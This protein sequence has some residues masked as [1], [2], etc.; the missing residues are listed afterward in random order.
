MT[1]SS[2]SEVTRPTVSVPKVLIAEADVAYRIVKLPGAARV[3]VCALEDERRAVVLYERAGS[4]DEVASVGVEPA[5]HGAHQRPAR[6]PRNRLLHID[7][8]HRLADAVRRPKPLGSVALLADET[9]D[10]VGVRAAGRRAVG[11]VAEADVNRRIERDAGVA[12]G[13]IGGAGVQVAPKA[14]KAGRRRRLS[15]RRRSR[16]R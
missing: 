16:G 9:V 15:G 10:A 7:P 11:T 4:V 2:V 1:P 8:D 5:F 12:Q 6:G 3:A 14:R 13:A